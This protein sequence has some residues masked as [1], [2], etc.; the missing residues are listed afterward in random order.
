V[1]AAY[2]S[3]GAWKAHRQAILDSLVPQGGIEQA[4]A[5]RV[6]LC[7]WRLNRVVFFATEKISGLQETVVKDVEDSG[8]LFPSLYR[9]DPTDMSALD[10][11]KRARTTY[12]DVCA[13]FNES[14]GAHELSAAGVDWFFLQAPY[15][16]S[17]LRAYQELEANNIP[18]PEESINEDEVLEL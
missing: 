12:E 8:R 15:Y 3:Q 14:N 7:S 9:E 6:A 13:L 4:L 5:E 18:N 10:K 17:E 11:V 1:V 16:A 2:E